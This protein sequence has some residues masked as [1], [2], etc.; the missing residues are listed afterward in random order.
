MISHGEFYWIHIHVVIRGNQ[1]ASAAAK[2]GPLRR[3]IN[4]PTPYDDSNDYLKCK[5][6]STTNYM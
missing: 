5:W 3:V 1:K 4:I 2:P 6:Q